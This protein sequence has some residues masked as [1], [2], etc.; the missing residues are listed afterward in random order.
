[1]HLVN[2]IDMALGG[3]V[4][5]LFLMFPFFP[6]FPSIPLFLSKKS[7]FIWNNYSSIYIDATRSHHRTGAKKVVCVSGSLS[8][9]ARVFGV[10]WCGVA[11]RMSCGRVQ[12]RLIK[13]IL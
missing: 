4:L 1:M 7:T 10:L 2:P 3:F 8:V 13:V 6:L 11:R 9:R 5:F 12:Q